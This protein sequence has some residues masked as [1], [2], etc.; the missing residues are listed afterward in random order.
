MTKKKILIIE[1]DE[2]LAELND[3]EIILDVIRKPFDTPDLIKRVN[4]VLS[5]LSNTV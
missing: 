1:D 3:Y 2:F 5:E 4:E